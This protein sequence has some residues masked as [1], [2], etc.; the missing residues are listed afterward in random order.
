MGSVPRCP[1]KNSKDLSGLGFCGSCDLGH[2]RNWLSGVKNPFTV[3]HTRTNGVSVSYYVRY[4]EESHSQPESR[5]WVPRAVSR[6]GW[7]GG[8][9]EKKRFPHGAIKTP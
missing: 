2:P 3:G 7:V 9:A 8:S 4:F 5:L 6:L 1:S